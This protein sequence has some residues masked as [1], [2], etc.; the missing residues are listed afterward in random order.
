ML[1]TPLRIGALALCLAL[2]TAACG[3][4]GNDKSEADIKKEL[5]ATLQSSAGGSIDKA[6]ADCFA[7]LVIDQVGVEE[8]NK[9]DLSASEPPAELRDK[10]TKAAARVAA[11]CPPAST[12]TTTG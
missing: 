1:R 2:G 11:E 6:T 4:S 12:T 8:L 7:G 9:V 10:I 3:S 5:S